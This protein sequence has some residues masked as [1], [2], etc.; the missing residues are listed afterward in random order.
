MDDDYASASPERS[1]PEEDKTPTSERE[2]RGFYSYGIAAEVFA[3]VGVGAFLPITL[4]Q[5]ARENGVLYSDRSTPC[6]APPGSKTLLARAADGGRDPDQCLIH[7]FGTDI[8]TASFAMYTFSAAVLCQAIVL[9]SFSS[10]ADY[11]TLETIT[12]RLS[13][14]LMM[15]RQQPEASPADFWHHRSSHIHVI[16]VRRA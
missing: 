10:F 11:G 2:L 6:V 13:S 4:E 12:T 15:G 16:Y 8:T 5:L 7:L 14:V 1:W 3:V 9:V